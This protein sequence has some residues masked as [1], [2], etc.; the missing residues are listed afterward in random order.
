MQEQF[1]LTYN[2]HIQTYPVQLQWQ[3]LYI[4]IL[5]HPLKS[6]HCV[7]ASS[8]NKNVESN[9]DICAA[10]TILCQVTGTLVKFVSLLRLVNHYYR[11]CHIFARIDSAWNPQ[12]FVQ[13]MA[14]SLLFP[15][16]LHSF[17]SPTH[18]FRFKT[19]P[20]DGQL[21]KYFCA[22]AGT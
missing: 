14:L 4:K 3:T 6:R 20:H 10:N 19:V 2:S 15:S 22:G 1:F 7:Q 17:M 12:T 11:S 9:H 5:F 8:C 18:P 13:A 21:N 16:F